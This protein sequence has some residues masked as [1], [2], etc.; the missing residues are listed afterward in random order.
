ME[1]PQTTILLIEDDEEDYF[2]LK[3]VLAKITH[4]QYTL[5]WESRYAVGLE[6]MLAEQHDLC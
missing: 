6:L 3:R 5:T 2:L 4:A 1:L